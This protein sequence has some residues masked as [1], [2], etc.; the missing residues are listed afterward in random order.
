MQKISKN[1][2]FVLKTA[3]GFGGNNAAIVIKKEENK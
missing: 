2:K 3:F 1:A